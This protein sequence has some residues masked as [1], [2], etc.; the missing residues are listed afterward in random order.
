MIW[1]VKGLRP[2]YKSIADFR[3]NHVAQLRE[4]NRDFVLLCRE[5]DLFG[6][7]DVAADDCFF[8]G[9]ASKAGIS[10]R[11]CYAVDEFS[12][13]ST[14]DCYYCPQGKRLTP[15]RKPV[16][17]S[18]FYPE[19]KGSEPRE[20]LLSSHNPLRPCAPASPLFL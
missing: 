16:V 5:L 4:V 8:R 18:C 14:G 2:F 17:L 12:Y 1:L 10:R 13:D 20:G 9:D 3:K 15:C 6:G 19:P 11:R 7:E